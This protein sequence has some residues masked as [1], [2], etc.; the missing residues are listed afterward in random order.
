MATL[1]FGLLGPV[2]SHY[3]STPVALGPPQRRAVLTAL[4]LQPGQALTVAALRERVWPGPPPPPRSPPSTCTST[5]CA[6]PWRGTK[7]RATSTR[8]A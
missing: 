3:G 6:A 5:T 7:A 1:R 2:T 4:L 8:H